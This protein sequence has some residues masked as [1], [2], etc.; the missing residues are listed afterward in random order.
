MLAKK[1][2]SHGSHA[3]TVVSK[4]RRFIGQYDDLKPYDR[5]DF[6]DV[7][8]VTD[9]RAII[10]T[11]QELY[12]RFVVD[13]E[14]MDELDNENIDDFDNDAYEY[15]D[16]AEYGVDVAAAAAL[17]PKEGLASEKGKRPRQRNN[18]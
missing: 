16:R 2:Q 6:S 17:E 1:E 9:Q 8:S 15:E 5:T 14:M 4:S 10:N 18:V 7:D 12:E 13:P 11:P 3:H